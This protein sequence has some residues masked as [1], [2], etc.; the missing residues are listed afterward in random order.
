MATVNSGSFTQLS[1]I[2][3]KTMQPYK[4]FLYPGAGTPTASATFSIGVT[5]SDGTTVTPV[6]ALD[7]DSVTEWPFEIDLTHYP[8][9]TYVVSTTNA[10]ASAYGIVVTYK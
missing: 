7:L 5:L 8:A 4:V 3:F 1:P 6:G 2:V 9:G 10:V